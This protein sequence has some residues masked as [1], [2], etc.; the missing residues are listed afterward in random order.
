M[1]MSMKFESYHWVALLL[2]L[3][4]PWGSGQA[5]DEAR[6][7]DVERV[8]AQLHELDRVIE[9]AR[10]SGESMRAFRRNDDISGWAAR[11]DAAGYTVTFIMETRKLGPVGVFRAEVGRDGSV[12][13]AVERLD[14][15]PLSPEL[16]EQYAARKAAAGSAHQSCSQDYAQLALPATNGS[17]WEVYLLPRSSFDDVL[18]VGGSYRVEVVAGG[19]RIGVVQ[20]LAGEGCAVLANAADAGVLQLVD[21]LGAG[22]NALHVYLNLLAGKPL[23]V[24]SGDRTWLIQNGRISL[25][26]AG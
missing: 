24:V 3:S 4:V 15:L 18:L 7:R 23:Y 8:G 13:G 11:A 26:P 9:S 21:E 20:P 22:P 19:E 17:G 5:Q 1:K 16:L 6:L 10:E 2:A 14:N 12:P 25:I